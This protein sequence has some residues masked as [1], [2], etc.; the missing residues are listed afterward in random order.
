MAVE[1]TGIGIPDHLQSR[2]FEKF[3]QADSSTTRRYGGTGLGL[4]ICKRL[5]ALMG[6]EVGVASKAGQGSTFWVTL[7]LQLDPAGGAGGGAAAD[8]PAQAGAA[9]G[10]FQV[11]LVE[12]NPTNQFLAEEYL[13]RIG[14]AVAVARSGH[15][16]VR[17]ASG[18]DFDA[19]LMDC[20]LPEL[21]GFGATA[22]I[23]RQEAGRRRVPIVALTAN[24]MPGD[25]ERCLAAGMDG[26]LS[27]PITL[28]DLT[29][30]IRRLAGDAAPVG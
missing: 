29:R 24:A 4:A 21:D 6:G 27:K 1:D 3:F 30:C 25:R 11:L 9:A 12:D 10:K 23:R 16:A 5:A 28:Q 17:L 22:E 26:Y 19:I 7:R 2:L 18:R 13:R 8:D 20:H 14:C 15:D